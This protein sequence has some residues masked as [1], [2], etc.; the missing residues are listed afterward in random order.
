MNSYRCYDIVT[1]DGKP[2]NSCV[3]TVP[4]IDMSQPEDRYENLVAISGA[5][6]NLIGP[7]ETFSYSE[8]AV[9]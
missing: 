2:Y 9:I 4:I 5:L 8:E 6:E 1:E 3:V 7:V